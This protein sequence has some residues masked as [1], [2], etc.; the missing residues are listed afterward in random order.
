MKQPPSNWHQYRSRIIGLII[1]FVFGLLWMWLGF[2]KAILITI[3]STIGYTF[4][5]YV[6]GVFDLNS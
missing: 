1:A 6:D 3:V 4:G 2:G 5:S